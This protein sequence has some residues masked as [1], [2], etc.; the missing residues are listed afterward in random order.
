MV[1]ELKVP[2]DHIVNVKPKKGKAK[3]FCLKRRFCLRNNEL[4]RVVLLF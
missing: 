2:G 3:R 4:I 1:G